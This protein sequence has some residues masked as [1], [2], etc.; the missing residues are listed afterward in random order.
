MAQEQHDT[1]ADQD[2]GEDQDNQHFEQGDAA[3]PFHQ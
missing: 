3:A 1:D 2:H